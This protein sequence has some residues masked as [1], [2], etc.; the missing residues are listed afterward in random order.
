MFDIGWSELVVLAIVA[1]VVVGPKELPGML[2]TF[3]KAMGGLKRT[4]NEFRA[5]FDE[6]VRQSELESLRAE[7]ES[8]RRVDP[9]A[10]IRKAIEG[11]PAG[12]AGPAAAAPSG[13]IMT[14]TV[15]PRPVAEEASAEPRPTDPRVAE[16]A[17]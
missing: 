5:Q 2:R 1:I 4:A 9:S 11:K 12:K 14:E 10:P 3:G 13:E 6:A 8:V 7:V 17:N 16:K 15:S